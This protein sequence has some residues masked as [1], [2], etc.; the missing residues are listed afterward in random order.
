MIP[1]LSG[2]IRSFKPA[3]QGILYILR[4]EKNT[5][6]HLFA[7]LVVT[8]LSILLHINGLEWLFIITAIFI[9][10][11]AELINTAIEKTIDLIT[12]EKNPRAKI[13]KDLS[14]G[15]VLLSAIYAVIIGIII[16]L[17]KILNLI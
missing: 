16:F 6:I 8:I 5:W 13:I 15:F 1:F 17:P 4:F 3:F 12:L 7:T 10:W 2:R 9:V 11:F 14:A